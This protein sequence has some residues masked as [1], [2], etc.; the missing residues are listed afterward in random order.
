MNLKFKQEFSATL[1]SI[2]EDVTLSECLDYFQSELKYLNNN[3]DNSTVSHLFNRSSLNVFLADHEGQDKKT[4]RITIDTKFPKSSFF[5]DHFY[6]RKKP[7][8][9]RSYKIDLY[10]LHFETI[11]LVIN[12]GFGKRFGHLHS[13]KMKIDAEE[14][15]APLASFLVQMNFEFSTHLGLLHS[16]DAV[17]RKSCV[18]KFIR[19]ELL[20]THTRDEIENLHDEMFEKSIEFIHWCSRFLTEEQKDERKKA[21]KLWR[22]WFHQSQDQIVLEAQLNRF[23]R[24]S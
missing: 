17:S 22:Q 16:L 21:F 4:A 24:S 12:Y 23:F 10:D 6:K 7:F 18:H 15:I 19:V 13:E 1:Q 20:E 3:I 9:N 14:N 5:Y 11:E 8:D 2:G